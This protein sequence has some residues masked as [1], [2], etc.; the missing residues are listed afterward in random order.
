[1]RPITWDRL[2]WRNNKKM[3]APACRFICLLCFCLCC[4][5]HAAGQG[6]VGQTAARPDTLRLPDVIIQGFESGRG[7]AEAP[8]SIGY[9]SNEDMQRNAGTSL[10][11]A[12]NTLPGVRMEERSPDSYRLSIR[13]SIL[14]SPFGVMN[15]KVYWDEI[16]LT[17]ASGNTYVNVMDMNAFGST[18]VLKGPAG[19]M[20]G[21]NTGGVVIFHGDTSVGVRAQLRAGSYG[22]YGEDILYGSRPG[23]A[24]NS[25]FQSHNQSD[26][27]RV[28]ST[29]KKDVYQDW[30]QLRLSARDRLD[31]LGSY[32]S[33][34]YQTPGG[35]TLQE[36]M[37]DPR[38]DRPQTTLPG[39]SQAH[40]AIYA[41]T[42]FAGLTNHYTLSDHWTNATTVLASGTHFDNP[43]LTDY[44]RRREQTLDATTKWIYTGKVNPVRVVLGADYQYTR[45]FIHDW[46]NTNGN[47]DT[48]QSNNRL[49][50]YQFNP[51]A[52]GEIHFARRWRVQAG[53]S[54]NTFNYHYLP[55]AGPDSAAGLQ[56]INFHLQIMPR[57]TVQYAI[58]PRALSA[59][60][61]VSRGYSPPTISEIFPGT[62]LL[63]NNL[64]PEAGWNTEVGLKSFLWADRLQLTL[65]LYDFRLQQT[66]VPRYDSAGHAYYVN[67][68]GTDQKGLEAA[69]SWILVDRPENWVT[70]LRWFTSYALQDYHFRDYLEGA[71]DYSGNPLTGVPRNVVV[72]GWNIHTQPGFYANVAYTYTD[73]VPLNDNGQVFAR[74]YQLVQAKLGW[75]G[76]WKARCRNSGAGGNNPD[77]ED[78]GAV[79]GNRAGV[80]RRAIRL[81]LFVGVDNALNQVYSLGDDFN[82]AGGRYYNPAPGRS[83]F[84]G[85]SL[86]F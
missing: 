46:G 33:L 48:T 71:A 41:Q 34:Y 6:A 1:M 76:Q 39:A 42:W 16:P 58:L 45:S 60:A 69:F 25:F 63:Y 50:A 62:A 5:F 56:R 61:T 59:Y 66:I 43:F 53:V 81:D 65:S 54:A 36:M 84:G 57:A 80:G 67:A 83:F 31:W 74:S 47:P 35:L 70:H 32:T 38:A 51:Y 52:Q 75:T 22:Q 8:S 78:A 26:G 79:P 29:S 15:V 68:G 18:E 4:A 17:D 23:A 20:Y 2:Y 30:G 85:C 12:I 21:A 9:I 73:K 86:R 72:S 3:S 11:P 55:L 13:G 37:Q 64:Q 49:Q 77:G 14:G 7:L 24:S 44:E 28:N 27:Y 82:A 40:A 19:S 10:L